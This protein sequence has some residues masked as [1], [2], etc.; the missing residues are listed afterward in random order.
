M[1]KIVLI[2]ILSFLN[3]FIW[4]PEWWKE[5]HRTK[6]FSIL[7]HLPPT[8]NS[9]GWTKQVHH[10][11][12]PWGGRN[13][14]TWPITCCLPGALHERGFERQGWDSISDTLMLEAGKPTN[15]SIIYA[16]YYITSAH[17][18]PLFLP[19]LLIK[20]LFHIRFVHSHVQLIAWLCMQA[21]FL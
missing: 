12:L 8:C 13:P 2:V 20:T 21:F 6:N 9:Q 11:S 5:R 3:L 4:K 17:P 16:A 19:S 14:S 18:L 1:S 10:L 15:S 7:V